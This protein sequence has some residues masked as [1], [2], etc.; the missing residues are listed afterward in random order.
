MCNDKVNLRNQMADWLLLN[1]K[2]CNRIVTLRQKTKEFHMFTPGYHKDIESW[3]NFEMKV[4]DCVL[5]VALCALLF[6]W[7]S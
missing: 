4:V 3:P 1:S 2:N 6:I 7:K 5:K